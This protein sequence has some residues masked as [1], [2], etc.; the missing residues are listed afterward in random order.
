[1][2]QEREVFLRKHTNGTIDA[3]V[4]VLVEGNRYTLELESPGG[5]CEIDYLSAGQIRRIANGLLN[6]VADV[7]SKDDFPSDDERP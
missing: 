4:S 3:A 2:R 7:E 6:F 5:I 1:M